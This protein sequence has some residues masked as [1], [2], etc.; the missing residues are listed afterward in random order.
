MNFIRKWV[1]GDKKRLVCD[2]YNLDLSYITP[3]IIAMAFPASGIESIYRNNID[4]VAQF[5]KEKHGSN[6][7]IINL[8]NRKY[9]YTKFDNKVDEYE[10]IDHHAPPLLTLFKICLSM[11]TFLLQNEKNVVIVNCQ[12]GKGRTGT[13]ICCFLLFSGYFSKPD[14]C[15]NYYSYKRFQRG[16]GVTQPSQRRYVIYF[17][18]M[19]NKEFEF[20]YN[21]VIKGIYLSSIPED[22][23]YGFKPYFQFYTK[24]SDHCDYSNENTYFE[25]RK[26]TASGNEMIN[27]TSNNFRFQVCGDVTIKIYN[28]RRLQSGKSLCRVSFNTAFIDAEEEVI[29]FKLKDIDP[30]NLIN[31]PKIPRNFEVLIQYN[32]MNICGHNHEF[33]ELC[34]KCKIRLKTEIE[35][36]NRIKEIIN[37][38]KE[39]IGDNPNKKEQGKILLYG[40]KDSDF[41]NTMLLLNNVNKGE[42]EVEINVDNLGDEEEGEGEEDEDYLNTSANCIII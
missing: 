11:K 16:Q 31:N 27:I 38:W 2:N 39:S 17:Y 4:E 40:S 1:S 33:D 37:I 36:W 32:I 6:Y 23:K 24:N 3:R 20:P 26:I 5:I 42:Q 25:Q 12:A 28:K 13:I 9:D 15:F 21:I 19:L 22:L 34:E 10:W 7:K 29:S 30:D 14:D 35:E 18:A 8:S 41:D